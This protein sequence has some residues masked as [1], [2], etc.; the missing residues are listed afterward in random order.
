MCH[1]YFSHKGWL[2]Q[3]LPEASTEQI[4]RF[5]RLSGNELRGITNPTTQQIE[6][7]RSSSYQQMMGVVA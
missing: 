5:E 2:R 1:L 7:A 6:K 3:F 4:N